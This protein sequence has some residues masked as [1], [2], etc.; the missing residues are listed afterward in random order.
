MAQKITIRIAGKEF[1][2]NANT[3]TDEELMRTAAEE[4]NKLYSD[5]SGRYASL[6]ALDVMML[7]SLNMTTSKLSAQRMLK[8]AKEEVTKFSD[9]LEAY[10]SEKENDR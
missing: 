9:E 4:I 2:L 7:V 5:F 10:L 8:A 6:T 3:P 1:N